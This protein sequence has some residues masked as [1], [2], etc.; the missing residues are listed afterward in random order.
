[1]C[2]DCIPDD[3]EN[4]AQ[5]FA[6]IFFQI[7]ESLTTVITSLW[8]LDAEVDVRRAT[9]K[10]LGTRPDH[11]IRVE[12][13]RTLLNRNLEQD[14]LRFMRAAEFPPSNEDEKELAVRVYLKCG[15]WQEALYRQREYKSSKLV[16]L[17]LEHVYTNR[18]P[19][20]IREDVEEKEED[21]DRM[22]DDDDD[23]GNTSYSSVL[24]LPLNE[25]EGKI[26]I[27]FLEN[28]VEQGD[29]RAADILVSLHLHHCRVDDALAI[30]EKHREIVVSTSASTSLQERIQTRRVL[31]EAYHATSRPAGSVKTVATDNV[32][33]KKKKKS[34]ISSSSSSSSKKP[35]FGESGV[36]SPGLFSLK[37]SPLVK[38]TLPSSR[39]TPTPYMMKAATKNRLRLRLEDE[40]QDMDVEDQPDVFG[41]PKMKTRGHDLRLKA[42]T[43][44][45]FGSPVV[46]SLIDED[47][48]S[49]SS[50]AGRTRS[51]RRFRSGS[52]NRSGSFSRLGR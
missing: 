51:G 17:I 22:D 13:L 48:K 33:L 39:R 4:T 44:E 10:L 46:P 6:S 36:Y 47:T 11:A 7:S 14:A 20:I 5:R 29:H 19:A 31:I 12:I 24:D 30:H 15:L 3:P 28:K 40:G 52:R 35:A 45:S 18:A 34:L 27:T 1:V 16:P 26:L 25:E 2:F 38:R 43:F 49:T 50:Y 21:E 42:A 32:P 37:D 41:T 9:S 23:I 8:R